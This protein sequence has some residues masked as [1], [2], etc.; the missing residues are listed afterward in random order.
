MYVRARVCVYVW[1]WFLRPDMNV[2]TVPREFRGD[3]SLHSRYRKNDN[4]E[5]SDKVWKYQFHLD[6]KKE[7]GAD[8]V[9]S[10]TWKHCTFP[11]IAWLS[12]VLKIS[13]VKA[14]FLLTL[15]HNSTASFIK[16][17]H[18]KHTLLHHTP[19]FVRLIMEWAVGR[20]HCSIQELPAQGH[21]I[22]PNVLT[23]FYVIKSYA[24]FLLRSYSWYI[25]WDLK[26]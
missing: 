2:F 12:I 10:D 24:S 26:A 16:P 18:T 23:L 8:E 6:N 13:L 11:L 25:G 9:Y 14:R 15:Y 19:S 1:E 3:V 5:F 22:A 20:E 7:S 4:D 17:L 21:C